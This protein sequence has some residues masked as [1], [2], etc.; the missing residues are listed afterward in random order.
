MSETVLRFVIGGMSCA[1]CSSRL[2]RVLGNLPEVER[3]AVNLASGTADVVPHES[4]GSAEARQAL[5]R[6]I[7]TRTTALG[8]TA[9][10]LS[11]EED[12]AEDW[13]N[14]QEEAKRDVALRKRRLWPEAFFSVLLLIVSMGHMWGLPLPTAIDPLTHPLRHALLQ[15]FLTVPVVWSGRDFYRL[16]LP[17][18]WRGSPNMDSLVAVGTG[19]ALL[20]SLWAT[21]E[22]ATTTD[23]VHQHA[24]VM[25]L[26]FESAAVLITLISF[27]KMLEASSRLRMSDA[28][29]ALLR[30]TPETALRVL[31]PSKEQAT[32]LSDGVDALEMNDRVD[33]K[34]SDAVEEVPLSVVH[35]GDFLQVRAGTRVPVDG[36]VLRGISAVDNA[37]LTG[38]SLPV[39]V[40]EGSEVIGGTMNTTGVFIMRAERVGADTALARM[41][42]LVRAAQGSKAPIARMADRISLIFVPT[43]MILA[44]LAFI[45]WY[46]VGQLPFT[47]ALRIFV[48]V[49]VVA[50]PCALGLATPISI[51]VGTGRGAHLGVL[52]KNG[53]ALEQAGRLDT[54]VFDKTGTL[55][56]GQPIVTH[57]KSFG[58]LSEDD[59]LQHAASLEA[60]SDH[61]LAGA[62]RRA[63]EE[64]ALGF[65]TVR[66]VLSV[67][68]KGLSGR[69]ADGTVLSL[70]NRL[71]LDEAKVALDRHIALPELEK[72]LVTLAD[73]GQSLLLL[74]CD[75]VLEGVVAVADPLR[76]EATEVIRRLHNEGLRVLLLSG[77]NEKTATAI[78]Q[79]AGIDEVIAGVLPE[80][81][82]QVI[83]DLR[84]QGLHVGMIGDGVNDA[85]ALVQA[86]VGMA[87]SSGMDVAVEA[88][89]IVLLDGNQG[90]LWG[91]VTAVL[92]GRA[93]LRNIRE[94]LFWAFAYNLLCLPVAAGLL[95]LFGGPGLSPMLAGAAMALSSVSVVLNATRLQKFSV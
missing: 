47:E 69:L 39:P 28:I 90:G 95:K 9:R 80:G 62:V 7:E 46:V 36:V 64:R 45:L 57:I 4:V 23:L 91:S 67:A 6:L 59:I 52:V 42:R 51:M 79:Q 5:A 84:A 50:C 31:V 14:R 16:G 76:P 27:G 54:L 55:T 43:V 19:A 86:H 13:K 2:E 82:A 38:E 34:M 75:D 77:D 83:A 22:I 93:T 21:V 1:A 61:P 11:E 8:F 78:A 68:G 49:L 66:D 65:V 63:A 30:L 53:S 10:A 92:L 20:Y 40:S 25:D 12:D 73:E 41:A 58:L 24:A 48:A 56:Q 26:Y 29:G 15:L 18:L 88:G 70:G 94:N 35:V 85:P 74:A 37:M 87:V 71:F 32:A 89:D 3:I 17:Q 72:T 81:K 44:I 60:M 33:V